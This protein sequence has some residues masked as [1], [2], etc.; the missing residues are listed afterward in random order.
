MRNPSLTALALVL[1]LGVLSAGAARAQT[2][3]MTPPAAGTATTTQTAPAQ[4]SAA[5]QATAP[6]PAG[7]GAQAAPTVGARVFG[8][9]GQQVGTVDSVTPQGVVINTG[10]AKVAVPTAAIGTGP[11]GPTVSLTRDQ[12]AGAAQQAQAAGAASITPGASVRSSD[13][14]AVVGTVK[15]VDAQFVTLTTAK[16]AEVRLPKNGVANGPN[17][18][19]VGMTA[20]QFEAAT[21]GAATGT[22]A[23]TG[24]AGSAGAAGSSGTAAAGGN[25]AATTGTTGTSTTSRTTT[26]SKKTSKRH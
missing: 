22:G 23:G 3:P 16:G 8:S 13:G 6:A 24:T 2:A 26:T 7:A 15:T 19:V 9:D 5:P 1:P 4:P 20:A 11:N 14:S 12:L 17:G 21:A 18:P 25:D 10:T